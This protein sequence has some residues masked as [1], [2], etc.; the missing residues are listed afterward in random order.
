[1]MLRVVMLAVSLMVPALSGAQEP[2]QA[3][4]VQQGD[5]PILRMDFPESEAIPGQPLSLRL[6]VLVPTFMPDPPVWPGFEAPDLMVRLPEKSTSPTSET[7]D[8]ESWSG[9]TR[10]YRISPMVPG[11]FTLPAQQM[12]VTWS[13]S[14]PGDVEQASLRTEPVTL[15]GVMPPG[16]EGLDPFVAAESL[17]L[18]QEIEGS[19]EAMAAGDSFKRV[20]TARVGGVSPIFL[21]Q[22]MQPADLPGLAAYDDAPLIEETD[23]RG[24]LGGTR[25]ESVTYIA[26]GGGGGELPAVTLD[27]FN[28]SSGQVETA[29]V[30]AVTLDVKGPPAIAA[31]AEERGKLMTLVL[32]GL[33]GLAVL[34]VAMHR[35]RPRLQASRN[36]RR[37]ACEASEAYAWKALQQKVAARNA[38][39][40]RAALDLWAERYDGPDPRNMPQLRQALYELGASEYGVQPSGTDAAVWSDLKRALSAARDSK[41]HRDAKAVLPPLNPI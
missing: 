35:F 23:D 40:M 10:H 41:N 5:G 17:N 31:S 29:Q 16:A 37:A 22:L 3:E 18:S 36:A 30:E 33:A 12:Q 21:P 38:H 19:P 1:M 28:I 27:W 4:A 24:K 13:G 39:G 34:A 20:I 7:V 32:A 11:E 25:R 8:G 15:R 26:E 14:K 9:I 2:P 6:T